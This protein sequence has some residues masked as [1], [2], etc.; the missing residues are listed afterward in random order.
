[1]EPFVILFPACLLAFASWFDPYLLIGTWMD[2]TASASHAGMGPELQVPFYFWVV[3]CTAV[4]ALLSLD[5]FVFHRRSHEPTLKEALGWTIFWVSL[6]MSFNVFVWWNFGPRYATEFF[7]GYLV[8]ESLSVDNLFV[9]L[10]IFKYFSVPMK[11]QYRVLFWGILG[12]I[13]MR[14]LFILA[15]SQL[16]MHFEWIFYIFGAFLIWTGFKLAFSHGV[17]PNPEEN[18]VLRYAHRW[19]RV[20]PGDHGDRFFVRLDGKLFVTS[21]FLVLLVVESTDVVFAVDSVPAIF[22]ISREPFI[23]FTSNIFAI[24]GLRAL[25]FV[26]AGVMDLFKYLSHG[27]SAILIFIGVKM[28]LHHFWEPPHWVSL[29]VIVGVLTV[30]VV[31]SVLASR[32]EA[33]ITPEE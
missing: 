17:D 8:E 11:Y 10:V 7:L 31:L 1:M 20:A 25:Y 13:V 27:L 29:S 22:G 5:M 30:S 15:A 18:V 12:A 28:M 19:L 21:L 9:F 3:F 6:A 23:I 24:L 14:M 26:L 32:R 2:G 4:I 16:I 33:K